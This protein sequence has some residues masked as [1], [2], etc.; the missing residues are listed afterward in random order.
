[1]SGKDVIV[2]HSSDI[3]V[4]HVYTAEIHRGDG[5]GG[6]ACVLNAAR[7]LGADVVL[8][9]GDTFDCHRL[10]D[11]LIDRAAEVIALGLQGLVGAE[12]VEGLRDV[13]A[14][15]GGVEDGHREPQ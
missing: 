11:D 8:L 10:P 14:A 3:H 15:V 12:P 6:L 1:M 4:D 5:T 9:A 13:A 7:G 2:V